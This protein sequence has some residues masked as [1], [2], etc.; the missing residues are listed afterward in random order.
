MDFA[1]FAQPVVLELQQSELKPVDVVVF[2]QPVVLALQ[3]SELKP[4][5]RM[6]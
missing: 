1:V 2:G 4:V 6:Q 5:V 3:Q